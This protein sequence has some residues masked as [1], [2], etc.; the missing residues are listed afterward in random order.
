MWRSAESISAMASS[1]TPAAFGALG[2]AHDGCRAAASAG[3]GR[4]SMPTPLRL[5]TR[6]RSA[7]AAITASE[8]GSTPASQPSTARHEAE[9]LGLVRLLAGGRVGES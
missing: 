1:A 8:T 6:R 2:R 9:Q 3:I 4:L 7:A 5:M